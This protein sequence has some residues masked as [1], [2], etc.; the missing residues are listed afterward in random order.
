MKVKADFVSGAH[1]CWYTKVYWN[2][3]S[4][5]QFGEH[6]SIKKNGKSGLKGM[7]LSSELVTEWID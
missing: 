3:V 2:F 7:T 5:E 1:V 6:T 4:S